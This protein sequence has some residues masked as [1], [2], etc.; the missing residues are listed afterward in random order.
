MSLKEGGSH[1]FND[2][3]NHWESSPGKTKE[4]F[5]EEKFFP[6]SYISIDFFP[7]SFSR[8]NWQ[9]TVQAR[10]HVHQSRAGVQSS[11]R[12]CGCL[13]LLRGTS[14]DQRDRGSGVRLPLSRV[15]SGKPWK[16]IQDY[17]R[18]SWVNSARGTGELRVVAGDEDGWAWR[19]RPSGIERVPK[20]PAS[21]DRDRKGDVVQG[22]DQ[23]RGHQVSRQHRLELPGSWKS[24][25]F[26]GCRQE[27][28][29]TAEDVF[30]EGFT[31][32]IVKKISS[33]QQYRLVVL[34]FPPLL[35]SLA[36]R[37]YNLALNVS[38]P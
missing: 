20:D 8:G 14:T 17:A 26:G 32:K 13:L 16:P 37:Y 25:K 3:E 10:R 22:Q 6:K 31:T 12:G 24:R 7:Y 9:S 4:L 21:R 34:A 35:C 36:L 1:H 28:K 5:R 29:M 38:S 33:C 2:K 15:L 27:I 30:P 19:S 11:S 23:A 18:P